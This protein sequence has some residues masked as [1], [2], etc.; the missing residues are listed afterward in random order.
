MHWNSG[1]P[2]TQKFVLKDLP[3]IHLF[4]KKDSGPLIVAAVNRLIDNNTFLEENR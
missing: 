1:L 3:P 2:E 4:V